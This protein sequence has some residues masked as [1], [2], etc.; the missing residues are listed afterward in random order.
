M[1]T[2]VIGASSAIAQALITQIEAASPGEAIFAVSRTGS[3]ADA[4]PGQSNVH[5]LQ[6]DYSEA[7]IAAVVSILSEHLPIDAVFICNGVLQDDTCF[8]EKRLNDLDPDILQHSVAV[9]AITP[10]LWLKHLQRLLQGSHFAVVTVFSAR[11]GSIDDNRRGGWY[12][13]RASKAALNMLIKSAAIEIRRTAP[14]TS[15]LVYH[16]GTTDTPLSRPFQKRID[17]DKLLT[18]MDS[19]AKLLK[20]VSSMD[21]SLAVQFLDWKGLEIAW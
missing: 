3:Q 4:R 10:V 20:V 14:N 18:A 17:N 16:P 8:P 21:R 5:W 7:S 13:Y 11:I 1:T 19:A 9:N 12:S 6:S 2:L 15:F